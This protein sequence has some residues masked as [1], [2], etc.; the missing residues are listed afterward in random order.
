MPSQSVLS[1]LEMLEQSPRHHQWINITAENGHLLSTFVA[2]VERK[3]NT[4][5]VIKTVRQDLSAGD[6]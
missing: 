3:D 1:P 2:F 4:D 5:I 6:L